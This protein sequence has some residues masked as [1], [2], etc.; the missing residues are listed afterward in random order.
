MSIIFDCHKYLILSFIMM[1]L[2]MI[3]YAQNS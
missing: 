2:I 1:I 3:M